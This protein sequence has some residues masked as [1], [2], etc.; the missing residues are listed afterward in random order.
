MTATIA[1]SYNGL[2]FGLAGDVHV[3]AA[4]GLDDLPGVKGDD[5][6]LPLV[7][8]SYPVAEYATPRT[9][10]F[11]FL[12]IAADE[13]AFATARDT[14]VRALRLQ[15]DGELPLVVGEREIW[16]RPSRVSTPRDLAFLQRT[17]SVYAEFVAT[18]PWWRDIGD[19]AVD[20]TVSSD[21]GAFFPML[22]PWR[23]ASSE[24]FA[25]ALVEND[26]DVAAWP[27]WTVTGPGSDLVLGNDTTGERLA[28]A[29]TF[30]PGESVTID[31]QPGAKTVTTPDG[32]SL[33][34]SLS[35]DSVLWALG[36]GATSVQVQFAGATAAS[37]V[38]LRYRRRWLTP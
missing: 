20:F 29:H 14:T 25:V 24:V 28:L 15:R 34:S 19:S 27:V 5:I 30:G 33:F 38:A 13:T 31:T 8:G 16:C 26:G 21:P 37:R 22:F 11:E 36:A 32:S 35:P 12:V 23:L 6:P 2:T 10:T 18:D 4:A 17:G 9:L 3:A 7:D 1:G